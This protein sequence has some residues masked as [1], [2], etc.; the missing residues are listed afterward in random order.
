MSEMTTVLLHGTPRRGHAEGSGTG[1][2]APEDDVLI[3]VAQQ[4]DL[5]LLSRT[6][7]EHLFANG[8]LDNNLSRTGL[9]RLPNVPGKAMMYLDRT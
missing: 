9:S 6:H 8:R 3:Y 1:L 5:G 2:V 4:Q 7:R